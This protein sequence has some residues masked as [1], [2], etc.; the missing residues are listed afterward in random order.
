MARRTT[1]YKIEVYPVT[2]D[3]TRWRWRLVAPNG[4]RLATSC[5]TQNKSNA[6]RCARR[7]H[8]LINEGAR[9]YPELVVIGGEIE[10]DLD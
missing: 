10:P 4:S 7:V 5:E 9:N 3:R 6:K 8:A 2:L 1:N